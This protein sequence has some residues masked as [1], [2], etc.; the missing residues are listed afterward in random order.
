MRF[1]SVAV[2]V[3]FLDALTYNV[4]SRY[5]TLPPVGARV[6]VPIGPRTVTG[7]VVAHNVS[8]AGETAP[9][10]VLDIVDDE[11]FLPPAIVDLCAWVAEYYIAGLGDAIGVAMPPGSR[12]RRLASCSLLSTVSASTTS[13]GAPG[14]SLPTHTALSWALLAQVASA[15]VVLI[16]TGRRCCRCS[17]RASYQLPRVLWKVSDRSAAGWWSLPIR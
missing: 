6:R 2:P 17:V 13:T 14:H 5:P 10:D 4:P 12:A 11:P 15:A 1:V 9:R 8:F 16:Q 3:P 7:C